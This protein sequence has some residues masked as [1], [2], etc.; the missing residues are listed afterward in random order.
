MRQ[1]VPGEPVV[2]LFPVFEDDGYTKHSGLVGGDFTTTVWRDGSPYPL[3]VTVTEEDSSGEYVI[4]YVP[5]VDGYWKIEIFVN[6][7]KEIWVSE[8][9]AG[10]GSLASIYDTL[11][12]IMDGGTGLFDPASDSLYMTSADL[13]RVLG[14]LHHNAILDNQQYDPNSQLISARLRVFDTAAHVPSVPGGSE[15]L[16]LLHEYT[17]ESEWGGLAEASRYALKRVS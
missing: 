14:L 13:T 3:A 11:Q 16:G 8:A 2:D 4:G 10:D 6:Y 5:P 1:I 7:N 9:I 15:T 17:I 12:Q